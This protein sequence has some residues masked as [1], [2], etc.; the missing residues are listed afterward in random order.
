MNMKFFPFTYLSYFINNTLWF[1]VYKSCTSFKFIP[2]YFIL[3]DAIVN[4]TVFLVSFSDWYSV[5]ILKCNNFLYMDL[6]SYKH[7]DL[8]Y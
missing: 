8:I 5:S 6:I 4:G 1:S 3:L 7:I 2:K